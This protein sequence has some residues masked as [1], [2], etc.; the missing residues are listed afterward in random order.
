M[1]IVSSLDVLKEEARE[2][3]RLEEAIKDIRGQV[4][5][6]TSEMESIKKRADEVNWLH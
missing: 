3:K 2:V 1:Q 5:A 6:T 4:D